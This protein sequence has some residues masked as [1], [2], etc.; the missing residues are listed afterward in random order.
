[1]WMQK[2]MLSAP[3]E[4]GGR[5]SSVINETPQNATPNS[6]IQCYSL[7]LNGQTRITDGI[8][9]LSGSEVHGASV[10]N[11]NAHL[12][13]PQSIDSD[14][15]ASSQGKNIFGYASHG[16]SCPMNN[17]EFQEQ[18]A[19]GTPVTPAS[20]AGIL[21]ARIGLQENLEKPQGLSPSFS[22]LDSLGPFVLDNWSYIPNHLHLTSRD[23]GCN[24]HM[25][26]GNLDSNGWASSNVTNLSSHAYVSPKFSNEP[27]LSL[28]TSPATG[29]LSEV[30]C[31]D[32]VTRCFNKTRSGLE[33]PSCS[34][35]ELA[36]SLNSNRHFHFSQ[37]MSGSRYLTGVQ[38]IL[39]QLAR[40]S[41]ENLEQ[42]RYSE[43]SSMF[44][45][46]MEAPLQ[47][48][49]AESKKS[50]LLTL[51]ELVDNRYN[52]CLDEI[53][54]V[55]SAFHAA[56]ELDPRVHAHFALQ[57]ISILYKNL[58]ERISNCILSMG[59]DFDN[60]CTVDNERSV[61]TSLIHKQ[62]AL[63]QLKRKDHQLWRPQRGLPENSVSVLR[64]WMF[65][66]FLHPY[67]K[68]SEKHLLALRTGLTRSQ[69]SNWFINARVRLWKP[70]IEE[71]Y[72]EL[73]HKRKASRN[74]GGIESSHGRLER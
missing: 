47:R 40:F 72:A 68:D 5:D 4:I 35:R 74:E 27:V 14:I 36:M 61:E 18:T 12:I 33:H 24:N 62:L 21:A 1:M 13:N 11:V 49:A 7:N 71:M 45:F 66:N 59:P 2:G 22:S 38:E 51:L 53:H 64:A 52:Q 44:K 16:T 48:H 58:R 46:H 55:V 43:A 23:H 31:S 28:A 3:E 57:T 70:M 73:D 10:S 20:L 29:Q 39:A 9:M 37:A 15:L 32:E 30:S 6:L 63:Q 19:G 60:L 67:P 42:V 56:T 25:P 34:N 26:D 69:V 17:S 54:T 50:Q 65:Q 41:L 8:S